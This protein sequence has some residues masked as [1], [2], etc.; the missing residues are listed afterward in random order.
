MEKTL[1]KIERDNITGIEALVLYYAHPHEKSV[2]NTETDISTEYHKIM[3]EMRRLNPD[4]SDSEI[5]D[6]L[7][8]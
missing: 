8:E 7:E 3:D 2:V 4:L 6:L 1:N 5:E